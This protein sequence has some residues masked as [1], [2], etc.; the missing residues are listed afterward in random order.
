[1]DVCCRREQDTARIVE[2][3]TVPPLSVRS[4]R[5]EMLLALAL[6]GAILLMLGDGST[7]GSWD[8]EGW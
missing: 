7:A 4:L 3:R 2:R 5:T 1:M 6:A 8:G